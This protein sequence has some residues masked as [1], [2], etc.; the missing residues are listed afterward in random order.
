MDVLTPF[1]ATWYPRVLALLR[2]VTGYLFIA[3]GTAKHLKIPR[4]AMF[5]N[6]PTWSL[7]GIAGMLEIVGGALI[8]G[9]ARGAWTG[10]CAPRSPDAVI[11][12]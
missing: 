11:R 8:R 3:H 1:Q 10:C 12:P 4:V 7:G 9:P 2:I 5:D 6:L